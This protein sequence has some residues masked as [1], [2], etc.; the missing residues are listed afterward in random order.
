MPLLAL[1]HVNVRTARLEALRRFYTDALG[2][3]EGPRPAFSFNGAW[4][5]CADQPVVHLVE[6]EETPSAGDD[7][8][9]QH[10]AFRATGLAECLERLAA[11][12]V[13]YRL[14]FVRDFALCQVNVHDPDGNHIH[15]DFPEAEARA[16]KLV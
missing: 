10:F 8:R 4:M 1:D 7:L 2:L 6:V 15:V 9:V 13:E 12:G 16:L 14:G 3:Q 11:Q 5:Y